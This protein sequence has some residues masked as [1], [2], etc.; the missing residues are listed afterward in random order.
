MSNKYSIKEETL[1]GLGDAL[2]KVNG[3]TRTYSPAEMIDEVTTILD[4]ATYILV[5]ENGNEYPAVYVDSEVI[6][7][8]DANDIREGKVAATGTGVVTGTKEI[9]A[10]HTSQGYALIPA[11]SAIAITG[12]KHY[13]YTKLQALICAF[14]TTLDNSVATEKVCI[15]DK[16]YAANSITALSTVTVDDTSKSINFGVTNDKSTYC[17]LRFFTYK[18]VY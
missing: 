14:N 18:E 4:S 11:G 17:L 1:V 3:T 8:A 9:P 12:L 16:V 10:Y 15:E 5:D 2:R 6:F 7:T 13:D